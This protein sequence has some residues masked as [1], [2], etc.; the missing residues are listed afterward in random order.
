MRRRRSDCRALA[1]DALAA[2]P[3]F[4][5][6]E[7]RFIEEIWRG[8]RLTVDELSPRSD[9]LRRAVEG[10]HLRPCKVSAENV[11]FTRSVREYLRGATGRR[12]NAQRRDA[13]AAM[14]DQI[15]E[16]RKTALAVAR[17]RRGLMS[18]SEI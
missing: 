3:A 6:D 12:T 7:K 16:R 8:R 15:A 10:R 18:E 14:R 4:T 5:D 17:A 9:T 11:R 13:A 2:D 1:A